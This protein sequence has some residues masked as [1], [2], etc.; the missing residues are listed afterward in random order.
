MQYVKILIVTREFDKEMNAVESIELRQDLLNEEFRR[1][2][3][4]KM[5]IE[6]KEN[7][8]TPLNMA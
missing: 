6:K 8:Q 3:S 4:S 1:I 2:D 5:L 7:E